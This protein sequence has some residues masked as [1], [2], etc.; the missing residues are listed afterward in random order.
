M[1]TNILAAG[2]AAAN[3]ATFTLAEGEELTISLF[4][5]A[6]STFDPAMRPSVVTKQASNTAWVSTR[7]VLGFADSVQVVRGGGTY[8]LER[9]D[10]PVGVSYGA[11]KG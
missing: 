10:Q 3:S 8:R 6:G 11:D 4:P 9:P 5:A 1:A 2:S 7:V